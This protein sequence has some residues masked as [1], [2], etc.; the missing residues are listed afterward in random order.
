MCCT[1]PSTP[2]MGLD[3]FLFVASIG[4]SL[5]F[6]SSHFDARPSG[7]CGVDGPS[8]NTCCSNMERCN[9]SDFDDS[10]GDVTFMTFPNGHPNH[11]FHRRIVKVLKIG[12]LLFVGNLLDNLLFGS[13]EDFY[14][15]SIPPNWRKGIF[16]VSFT[17]FSIW[18]GD[19]D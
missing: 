5:Y 6:R 2:R 14:E 11:L 18:K 9:M 1:P 8:D 4:L 15:S 16:I 12:T 10:R 7:Q 13:S 3:T 19:L 17:A